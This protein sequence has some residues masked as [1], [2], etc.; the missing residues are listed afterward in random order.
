[1]VLVALCP[2]MDISTAA[3]VKGPRP[4]LAYRCLGGFEV[5]VLGAIMSVV[6]V[7]LVPLVQCP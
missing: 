3:E 1:M 6:V 4:I 2:Y 5:F 7:I